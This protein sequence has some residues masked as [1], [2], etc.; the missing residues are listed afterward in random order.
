MLDLNILSSCLEQLSVKLVEESCH[1]QVKIH[2]SELFANA[3][4]SS[5]SK[6]NEILL[7]SPELLSLNQPTL[8]LEWQWFRIYG[9]E[10]VVAS[11]PRADHRA[12]R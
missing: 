1:G 2:H 4:P 10:G 11:D 9:F 7:Q 12:S 8:R 3:A 6:W 5:T